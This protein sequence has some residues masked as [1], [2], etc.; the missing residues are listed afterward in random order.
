MTGDCYSCRQEDDLAAASFAE[1]LHVTDHWRVAHAF[2]SSL[3]GWLVV[4]PRRHVTSIA[5]LTPV[6]AA[7]LGPLLHRLS[8]TLHE[9]VRCT[10]TYVMQFAE[11]EGFGHVHFHL[12]PRMPDL[13]PEHRG[14]RIFHYLTRPESE[15]LTSERRVEITT[16]IA[17]RL[18]AD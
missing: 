11:A 15:W 16:A 9:T 2:N 12:V 13:P 7:E 1:R 14:P 8:T 17:D 5:E 18:R 10:K 3:P 6:E 4:L